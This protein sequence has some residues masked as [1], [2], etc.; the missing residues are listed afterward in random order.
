LI[1]KAGPY[2][3]ALVLSD[4]ETPLGLAERFADVIPEEEPA[5]YRKI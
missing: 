1:A 4:P 3:V 2:C 5:G